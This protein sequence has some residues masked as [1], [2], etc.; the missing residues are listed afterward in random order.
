LKLL[1]FGI[2]GMNI[3]DMSFL[4]FIVDFIYKKIRFFKVLFLML[5]SI[6]VVVG[7]SEKWRNEMNQGGL[8]THMEGTHYINHHSNLVIQISSHFLVVFRI[9]SSF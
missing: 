2:D 1:P 4:V 8:L 6:Y 5:F 3:F 7:S 9:E